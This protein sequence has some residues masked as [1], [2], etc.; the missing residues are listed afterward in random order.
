MP[1]KQVSDKEKDKSARLLSG[2]FKAEKCKP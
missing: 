1:L 2:V